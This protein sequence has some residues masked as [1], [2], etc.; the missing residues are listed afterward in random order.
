MSAGLFFDML[1]PSKA[2]L[3]ERSPYNVR[4]IIPRYKVNLPKNGQSPVKFPNPK[5]PTEINKAS[6]MEQIAQTKNTCSLRKPCL[7]TKIF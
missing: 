1:T 5:T 6:E 2:D 3:N 7:K 4:N